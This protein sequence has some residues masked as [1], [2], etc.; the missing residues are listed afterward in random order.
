M[1]IN[2]QCPDQIN[3]KN[4]NKITPEQMPKS[5]QLAP[6]NVEEQRLYSKLP[7]GDRAPNPIPKGVPSHPAKEAHFGSLYP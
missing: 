5:P 1:F 3:K 6:L 2:M 4:K 7:P